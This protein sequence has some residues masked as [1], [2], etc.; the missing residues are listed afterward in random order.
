MQPALTTNEIA[1]F[2]SVLASTEH[3]AGIP[4][5]NGHLGRHG[6]T[7]ATNPGVRQR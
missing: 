1:L 6:G 2:R 5:M 4:P 7:I 3:Y